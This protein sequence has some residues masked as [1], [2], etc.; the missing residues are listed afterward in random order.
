MAVTKMFLPTKRWK[1]FWNFVSTVLC[2]DSFIEVINYYSTM[3]FNRLNSKL[4]KPISQIFYR[5]PFSLFK[6]L[7]ITVNIWGFFQHF[8]NK[9][10]KLSWASTLR[11]IRNEA[12]N[13]KWWCAANWNFWYVLLICKSVIKRFVFAE[14]IYCLVNDGSQLQVIIRN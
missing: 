6:E 13:E 14:K 3:L 8:A 4:F 2:I 10:E 9:L 1:W 5:C 7:N 11:N 12:T